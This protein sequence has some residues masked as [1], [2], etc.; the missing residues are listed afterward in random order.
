MIVR[1]YD[2]TYTTFE[3]LGHLGTEINEEVLK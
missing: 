2:G 3:E 1:G